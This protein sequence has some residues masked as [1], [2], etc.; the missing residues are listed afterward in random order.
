MKK[1]ESMTDLSAEELSKTH[2]IENLNALLAVY[3]KGIL[4]GN[5]LFSVLKEAEDSGKQFL[6]K[7]ARCRLEGSFMENK[8]PFKFT[9]NG[10]G[11]LG[12]E[13]LGR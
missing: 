7:S 3:F 8:L 11:M 1:M 9:E 10:E 2:D 4:E 13:M 12:V 5:S 6:I